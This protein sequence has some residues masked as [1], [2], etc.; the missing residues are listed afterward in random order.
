MYILP[1]VDLGLKTDRTTLISIMV[2]LVDERINTETGITK[3][4]TG[5][6]AHLKTISIPDVQKNLAPT[7]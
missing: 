1:K 3:Q 2:Y 6:P 7:L 4:T 5:I